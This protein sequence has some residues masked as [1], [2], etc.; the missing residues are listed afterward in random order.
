MEDEDIENIWKAEMRII[1][2]LC[3]FVLQSLWAQ[4]ELSVDCGQPR[5][6]AQNQVLLNLVVF[7]GNN[8]FSSSWLLLIISN[9]YLKGL[10]FPILFGRHWKEQKNPNKTNSKSNIHTHTHIFVLNFACFMTTFLWNR[11]WLHIFSISLSS[12]Y[13]HPSSKMDLR[14]REF[15]YN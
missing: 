15:R 10:M 5:P 9:S 2:Q 7:W 12:I 14:D 4:K 8:L 1:D 3:S 11:G 13:L 6:T